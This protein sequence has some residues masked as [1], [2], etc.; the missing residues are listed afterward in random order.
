M[1]PGTVPFL[2]IYPTCAVHT[3]LETT[4]GLLE[5]YS[6]KTGTTLQNNAEYAGMI[7]TVDNNSGKIMD[8]LKDEG[9][10]ENTFII[11]ASDILGSK[12]A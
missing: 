2:Y 8:A 7:E 1:T 11:F 9:L 3:P 10:L 6:N 12:G 5:K 4:S